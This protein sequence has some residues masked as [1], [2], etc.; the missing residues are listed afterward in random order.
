[1]LSTY[2]SR[3]S[4]GFISLS[5]SK[6]LVIVGSVI[7]VF[8]AINLVKAYT[9]N[10]AIQDRINT[11]ELNRDLVVA[12]NKQ[13]EETLTYVQ[14]S[15]YVEKQAR[16]QLNMKRPGEE[17]V[18]LPPERVVPED[19]VPT[20]EDIARIEQ[21]SNPQKWFDFFFAGTDDT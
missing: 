8:M 18:S 3:R 2:R 9:E 17:V 19:D 20:A 1:M 12:E 4:R 11:L 21:S 14:S 10:K 6:I 13:L 16:D 15:Y 7:S 5:Q